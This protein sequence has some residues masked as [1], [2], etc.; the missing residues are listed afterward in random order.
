MHR[1]ERRLAALAAA[2][3]LAAK[4]AEMGALQ[5]VDPGLAAEP[6]KR[7]PS[8]QAAENAAKA[9]EMADQLVQVSRPQPTVRG[10]CS[11]SDDGVGLGRWARLVRLWHL[12]QRPIDKHECIRLSRRSGPETNKPVWGV[13]L[14][15]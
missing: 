10:Q 12:V 4:R 7:E 1:E 11:K 5:T 9:V 6:E 3:A 13:G 2:A 8:P 15:I 14:C